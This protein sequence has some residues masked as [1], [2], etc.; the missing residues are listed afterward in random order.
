[1]AGGE[2]RVASPPWPSSSGE[3]SVTASLRRGVAGRAPP[4]RHPLEESWPSLAGPEQQRRQHRG[5]RRGIATRRTV[6][7]LAAQGQHISV[8]DITAQAAGSLSGH[9]HPCSPMA[10]AAAAG[11]RGGSGRALSTPEGAATLLIAA[12]SVHTCT[13]KSVTSPAMV[14]CVFPIHFLME[15][16]SCLVLLRN[17]LSTV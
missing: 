6:P 11:C 12:A 1:L 5:G 3:S 14:C 10:A 8:Q 4:A 2:G 15:Y 13:M 17:L 7:V 16:P 9:H